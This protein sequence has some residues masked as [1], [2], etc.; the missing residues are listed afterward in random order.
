M[1]DASKG[2]RRTIGVALALP[3]PWS[4]ELRDWRERLGDPDARQIPPHVTLLPPTTLAA[5]RDV[6]DVVD[7]LEAVAKEAAAFVLHLRGT[8]TFRP[9]SPV[10][11][12]QLVQGMAE[13]AL[14]EQAVRSG[15]LAREV[16]F[17]YYPHV[18]VAHDLAAADLDRAERELASY[19]A[20]IGVTAITL[21]ERDPDGWWRA[22]REFPFPGSG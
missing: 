22:L 1:T 20:V 2:Q 10:V 6:D 8:A 7:H 11:F 9:V 13:C 5:T 15:P 18:T 12:V 21:F 19:D 17:A 3:D 14:L 16:Q 4:R